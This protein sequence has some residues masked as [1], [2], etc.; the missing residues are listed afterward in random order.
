M[1]IGTN[2]TDRPEAGHG[3]MPSSARERRADV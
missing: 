2:I 1:R 3:F